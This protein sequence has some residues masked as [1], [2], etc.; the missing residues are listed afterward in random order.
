MKKPELKKNP[1]PTLREKVAERGK[2]LERFNSL[3]AEIV[4]M[5]EILK[6]TEDHIVKYIV[7]IT[8]W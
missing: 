2:E 5:K 6:R 4:E 8:I 7:D 3:M 1:K